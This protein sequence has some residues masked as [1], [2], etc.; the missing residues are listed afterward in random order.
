MAGCNSPHAPLA[1]EKALFATDQ[2]NVPRCEIPAVTRVDHSACIQ[3]V[4]HQTNPRSH[5]LIDNAS[6]NGR[7][8]PVPGCLEDGFRCIMGTRLD[9]LVV[10]N[11]FLKNREQAPSPNGNCKDKFQLDWVRAIC[12]HPGVGEIDKHTEILSGLA[13]LRADVV[14]D[15]WIG[16]V[17]DRYLR[18][19]DMGEDITEGIARPHACARAR[20]VRPSL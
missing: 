18:D 14:E 2:P 3:T 13:G 16:R 8:D 5:A 20:F 1:E 4:P 6:F 15:A 19:L 17:A 10:G 11:A 9:V 7:N 12:P